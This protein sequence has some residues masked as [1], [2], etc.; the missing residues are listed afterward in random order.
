MSPDSRI[1]IWSFYLDF[2][3]L[4]KI[5]VQDFVFCGFSSTFLQRHRWPWTKMYTIFDTI[6]Q[7]SI[8]K[9]SRGVVCLI[10]SDQKLIRTGGNS[11]VANQ[12]IQYM[13]FLEPNTLN[14]MNLIPCER[15]W[16]TLPENGVRSCVHIYLRSYLMC[17]NK[18]LACM[19][20]S[21]T[22]FQA[23]WNLKN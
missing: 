10:R 11:L 16:K 8:C 19:H 14:K 22:N 2:I 21:N 4:F 12:K 3:H 15:A 1:Y 5:L 6:S 20:V 17:K 9:L 7:L 13:W 23:L 18:S